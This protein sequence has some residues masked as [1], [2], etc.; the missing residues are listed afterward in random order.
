MGKS[1]FE[2]MSEETRHDGELTECT[3]DKLEEQV[4][5]TRVSLISIQHW[6][7]RD[8]A[9]RKV[10]HIRQLSCRY[11]FEADIVFVSGERVD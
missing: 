6:G 10:L 3:G 1:S 8:F 11:E 4:N 2:F 9:S 7:D 5:I